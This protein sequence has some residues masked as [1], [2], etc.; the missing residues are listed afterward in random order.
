LAATESLRWARLRENEIPLEKHD[1]PDIPTHN[2][3]PLE[4]DAVDVDHRSD[5]QRPTPQQPLQ[6]PRA[7]PRSVVELTPEVKQISS[8]T[9]PKAQGE[10]LLVINP[11]WSAQFKP[12]SIDDTIDTGFGEGFPENPGKGD[13]FVYTGSVPT[14]LFKYNGRDWI[15]IDKNSTDSYTH[16]DAYIEHLIS[17][18]SSGQYDPEL[19]SD[20]ERSE[21]EKRLRQEI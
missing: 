11:S 17:A 18:I 20:A 14:S 9:E 10:S 12:I 8:P 16:N 13:L 2:D 19:L 7:T 4:H 6:D 3:P 21:I 15:I 5:Q 1:E